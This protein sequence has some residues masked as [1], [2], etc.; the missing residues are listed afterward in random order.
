MYKLALKLTVWFRSAIPSGNF[1]SKRV[2]ILICALVFA[3][4]ALGTRA[5]PPTLEEVVNQ[6][7]HI[8]ILR[9][10][11]GEVYE[12]TDDEGKIPCKNIYKAEW[13]ES[14]TNDVG[15][16]V[17]ASNVRFELGERALVYLSHE[18]M[19][20]KIVSTSTWAQ[21]SENK[22]RA[23]LEECKKTK[24][25]LFT[26]GSTSKFINEEHVADSF[27]TGVWV[28]KPNFWKLDLDV[29]TVMPVA[30]NIDG[31][32]IERERFINEFYDG[33][34]QVVRTAGY[35]LLIFRAVDWSEYREELI[36]LI[37]A[38]NTNPPSVEAAEPID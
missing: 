13:E 8:G 11:S 22:R 23:R 37:K 7:Q 5:I 26:V 4:S 27:K 6:A 21:R 36:R 2:L 30:Y 32:V 29:I 9:I 3:P 17:F 18:T 31:E 1:T 14:Y 38:K 35:E 16:I 24:G 10:V 28:E 20:R 33:K 12:P 15:S 25:L 19:Q 34:Y